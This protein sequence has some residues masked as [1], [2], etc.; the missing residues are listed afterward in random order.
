VEIIGGGYEIAAEHAHSCSILIASTDF[1]I[2]GEWHTHIDYS[3]FFDLLETGK[4]FSSLDYIAK[5]PEWAIFGAPEA[6]FDPNETRFYRKG[7]SPNEQTATAEV[8][9]AV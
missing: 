6:G 4:P 9:V 3:K 7:K 8:A 2:N 5:T 1:K